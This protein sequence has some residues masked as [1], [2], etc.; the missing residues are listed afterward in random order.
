MKDIV[1]LAARAAHRFHQAIDSSIH[2]A[3]QGF[4]LSCKGLETAHRIVTFAENDVNGVC[5]PLPFFSAF[6]RK[7]ATGLDR[8][9]LRQISERSSLAILDDSLSLLI[10]SE[11]RIA[12]SMVKQS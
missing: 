8:Y 4:E 9:L 2:I 1:T 7:A 11:I 10:S 3:H 5:V 12:S 6:L